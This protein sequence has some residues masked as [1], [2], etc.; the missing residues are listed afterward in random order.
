MVKQ[1][2]YKIVTCKHVVCNECLMIN[3]NSK[4]NNC[5]ICNTT[6]KATD[7]SKDM[8][9]E[10]IVKILNA[11][12]KHLTCIEGP[13]ILNF[14]VK[15]YIETARNHLGE[16]PLH[17]MCKKGDVEQVLS[18]IQSNINVDC[19]DNAGWTALVN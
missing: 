3:N 16:T 19:K 15:L 6:Y 18:L 7:I 1:D 13:H 4:K 14:S 10:D 9:K 2:Q 17:R 12:L 5:P 11:M 8:L